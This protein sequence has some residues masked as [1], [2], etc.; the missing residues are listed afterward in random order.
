MAPADRRYDREQGWRTTTTAKLREA[1][2]RVLRHI[3]P[4]ACASRGRRDPLLSR[5][6]WWPLPEDFDQMSPRDFRA[7]VRSARLTR[8]GPERPRT[9]EGPVQ[10]GRRKRTSL[11]KALLSDT[12]R[13]SLELAEE[14]IA[15]DP[16]STDHRHTRPDGTTADN[17]ERG[18]M[19]A[20]RIIDR[21]TEPVESA[22]LSWTSWRQSAHSSS[23]NLS[24]EPPAD[25]GSQREPPCYRGSMRHRQ[26][27]APPP[28]RHQ[29]A[30]AIPTAS[31]QTAPIRA[32]LAI[33][34]VAICSLAYISPRQRAGN[35]GP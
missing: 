24:Y 6:G 35:Y 25:G 16:E 20:F 30:S 13:Q 27:P 11:A 28:I 31:H 10:S 17:S 34:A 26:K 1:R 22:D 29:S 8:T 12:R 23:I 3:S 21:A 18:I 2:N 15:V 32:C 5:R 14:A 33:A 4:V 9:G 19:V 7:V